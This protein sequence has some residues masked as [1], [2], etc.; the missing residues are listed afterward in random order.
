MKNLFAQQG[1]ASLFVARLRALEAFIRAA[2]LWRLSRAAAR[3]RSACFSLY[4]LVRRRCDARAASGLSLAQCES[5]A[6]T[7]ALFALYLAASY[8]RR[9]FLNLR[10]R[11][12]S[13]ARRAGVFLLASAYSRQRCLLRA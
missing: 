3:R 11:A 7:A 13:L 6:V 9:S 5:W 12:A 2:Y 4:R 8:T 1:A 10:R